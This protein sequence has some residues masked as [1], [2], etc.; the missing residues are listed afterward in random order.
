M[1]AILEV[2]T[3]LANEQDARSI[4]KSLVTARLAA[5]AQIIPGVTSI[6]TWDD[7]LQEEAEVLLVLKTT[8]SSWPALRDRLASQHPYDTPE[9]IA[10]EVK[11]SSFDYAT[12]VREGCD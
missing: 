6:Y 1:S 5:C 7:K 2:K 10:V 8:E 11:Q 12:W 4:G 3:T 9:I